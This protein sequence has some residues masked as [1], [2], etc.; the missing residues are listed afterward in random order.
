MSRVVAAAETKV[1]IGGRYRHYKGNEYVVC[2]IVLHSETLEPLV[3]YEPQY[4]TGVKLWVRP[5]EMFIEEVE[6]DG[7]KVP[8]FKLVD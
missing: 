5:L 8:R 3:L 1:K 4:E 2:G 6:V 7:K